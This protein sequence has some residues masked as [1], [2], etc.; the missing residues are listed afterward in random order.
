MENENDCKLCYLYLAL[1]CVV[2]AKLYKTFWG[3]QNHSNKHPNYPPGPWNLPIVGYMPF[4]VINPYKRLE[5]LGKTYGSI[6]TIYL[7]KYR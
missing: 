4:L 2:L 3:G 1:V 6:F 5:K 7:G